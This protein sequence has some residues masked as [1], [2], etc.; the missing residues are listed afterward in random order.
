M[1]PAIAPRALS[2]KNRSNLKGHFFF[3]SRP[4]NTGNANKKQITNSNFFLE[5]VVN[6]PIVNGRTCTSSEEAYMGAFKTA[7]ALGYIPQRGITYSIET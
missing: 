5:Q 6:V 7:W 2:G 4:F 1:P 3:L